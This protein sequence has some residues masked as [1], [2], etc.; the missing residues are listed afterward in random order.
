M[1][2]LIVL[3]FLLSHTLSAQ[4]LKGSFLVGGNATADF[5]ETNQEG[6][7]LKTFSLSVSPKAGY[8]VID[9]FCIGT[10]LP[11]SVGKNK[12]VIEGSN[13]DRYEA[14]FSSWGL[15]P[16]VRYYFPINKFQIITEAS[17][18]WNKGKSEQNYYDVYTGQ[19]SLEEIKTS[20]N[21]FHAA[22]GAGLLLSENV[23]LE[24]LL[25]YQNIDSESEYPYGINEIK[26]N[27]LFF[28]IGF[29]IYLPKSE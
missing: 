17:Y 23:M 7:S 3:L 1:R 9:N 20:I 19:F 6:A 16:L 15:G 11:L 13:P 10:S 26:R 27:R 18:T 5:T 29:Q 21:T 24:F 28:S 14:D 25:N 2:Y 8:F 4:T 22:T 12:V